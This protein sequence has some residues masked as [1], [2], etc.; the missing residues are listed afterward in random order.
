MLNKFICLRF[1]LNFYPVSTNIDANNGWNSSTSG[2]RLMAN[3]L[4]YKPQF[5]VPTLSASII[6]VSSIT[7]NRYSS[8]YYDYYIDVS[9]VYVVLLSSAQC[10]R[11]VV[12]QSSQNKVSFVVVVRRSIQLRQSKKLDRMACSRACHP[13]C[14]QVDH[15]LL[16]F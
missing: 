3:S 6:S 14:N 1:S 5:V 2:T 15:L 9:F 8:S 16:Y 12:Q 13:P 11:Q 7:T 4:S 10:C